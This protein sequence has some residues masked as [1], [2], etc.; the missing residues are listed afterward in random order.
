MSVTFSDNELDMLTERM[1]KTAI[2]P[3]DIS[4]FPNGMVNVKTGAVSQVLLV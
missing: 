3:S 2:T 1:T 4:S